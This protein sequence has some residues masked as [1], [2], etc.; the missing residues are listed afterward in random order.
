MPEQLALESF[1]PYLLNRAGVQTGQIFS[2]ALKKFRLTLPEWRILIAL[3]QSN[4]QRLRDL[5]ETTVVDHSTLSRQIAA[6]ERAGLVARMRSKSDAR[7]LCIA[8]TPKGKKLTARIIPIARAHEA[9][10]TKGLTE[11]QLLNLEHCLKLIYENLK[12]FE[13]SGLVDP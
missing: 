7:A 13:Q 12:A 5:A 1:L 3:W 8:L 10:A 9:A 2:L 11:Q 4:D 6:L